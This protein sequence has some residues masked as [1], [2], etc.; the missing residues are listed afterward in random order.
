MSEFIKER[1]R[2]L[3]QKV[4]KGLASRNMEG[5]FVETKEEAL[6]KAL[7]IIPEG[8]KVAW[9]GTMSAGEIGLQEVI[10][11]GNYQ[12]QPRDAAT[13][14]EEVRAAELFAYGADYFLA[15]TNAITEDGILINIDGNSN[16]VSA[17]AYG[18][19]HVLMIVGMNK[20]A[21][22]EESALARARGIAATSNAQRFPLDTP[23]KKTGACANCKS[24]DTICCQFLTTRFSKHPGRIQIILVNEDLGF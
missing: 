8:A 9:G 2:L 23:C 3:A 4:I 6:K 1:N 21:A 11:N 5:F 19:L 13:T 10:L 15:S 14:P 7:E 24:P 12:T 16:R 17:I 22:D 18:P 20:V